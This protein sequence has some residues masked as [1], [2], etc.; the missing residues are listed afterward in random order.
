MISRPIA[1]FALAPPPKLIGQGAVRSVEQ[2]L[3]RGSAGEEALLEQLLPGEVGIDEVQRVAS[4]RW[5]LRST[6]SPLRR[7]G[8][9]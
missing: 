6:A 9:V 5:P 3:P 2:A 4:R 1:S 7:E 8:L